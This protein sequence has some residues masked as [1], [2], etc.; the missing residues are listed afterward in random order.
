MDVLNT[1]EVFQ[2][3]KSDEFPGSLYDSCRDALFDAFL[4]STVVPLFQGIPFDALTFTCVF[5]FFCCTWTILSTKEDNLAIIL[6]CSI[7]YL[8][9]ACVKI[10]N[11]KINF[12]LQVVNF[13]ERQSKLCSIDVNNHSHQSSPLKEMMQL[14]ILLALRHQK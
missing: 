13:V 7:A 6:A 5:D 4:G 10:F 8:Q 2:S 9:F 3:Q 14:L 12:S 1:A 11:L